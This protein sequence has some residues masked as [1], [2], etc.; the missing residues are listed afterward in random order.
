MLFSRLS[1]ICILGFLGTSAT[2][3]VVP[4]F[5][6]SNF[7]ESFANSMLTDLGK[8][9]RELG[10]TYPPRSTGDFQKQ[11]SGTV[12][13][14]AYKVPA[15][16]KPTVTGPVA[17]LK[18]T[19]VTINQVLAQ[20]IFYW[21]CDQSQLQF[22]E[23]LQTRGG[24]QSLLT[25]NEILSGQRKF[26][27]QGL[28]NFRKYAI[29]DGDQSEIFAFTTT[30]TGPGQWKTVISF[31]EVTLAYINVMASKDGEKVEFR[32]FPMAIN[33]RILKGPVNFQDDSALHIEISWYRGNPVYTDLRTTHEI[34][35]DM[36]FEE[37]T[38]IFTNEISLEFFKRLIGALM[39]DFPSSV[40]PPSVSLLKNQLNLLLA[41]VLSNPTGKEIPELVKTLIGIL[42]NAI[43]SGLII[44][45]RP[46]Q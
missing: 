3:Q 28:E 26:T 9:L 12:T 37:I 45:N 33:T 21:G 14:N 43:D 11:K 41:Q 16:E 42:L 20:R 23:L 36:M 39:S 18:Y 32:K 2:A 6:A 17:S 46:V 22:V 1:F 13:F 8:K 35:Y 29:Q 10:G 27:L 30:R 5:S 7:I 25:A 24:D 40:T 44:D 31:R 19:T 38:M 4:R 15:C 34:S